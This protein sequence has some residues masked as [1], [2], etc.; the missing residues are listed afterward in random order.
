MTTV[1]V[2]IQH[3]HLSL[4]LWLRNMNDDHSPPQKWQ[5]WLS[6]AMELSPSPFYLRPPAARP[7]GMFFLFLSLFALVFAGP[8]SDLILDLYLPGIW[9]WILS[10]QEWVS[11]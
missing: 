11:E 8:G 2:A 7:R 1:P 5:Q 10:F 6:S 3:I 9:P 4:P